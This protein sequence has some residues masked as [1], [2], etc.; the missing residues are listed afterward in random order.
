M[1]NRVHKIQDKRWITWRYVHTKEN[2]ADLGSRGGHVTQDNDLWWYGPKWLSDP[3]A[4]PMDVTTTAT[5]ETLSEAKVIREI[6]KLADD[7]ETDELEALLNKHILWKTLRI[8][9]WITRFARNARSLPQERKRGPLTTE[10]L[11]IQ[12]QAWERRAQLE[13]TRSESFVNDRLQ[14]NLQRNDQHLFECRGRIQGVYP[15]YLPDKCVY[16][17]KFIQEAH[18]A[19]LHGGVQLTMAKV[20]EQHW[21]PRLRRQVKRIVKKCPGCKRFQATA[22]AVPPPGLLPK[23]RTEGSFPFQV[24]GVD[25]AGPIKYKATNKREGKAY[26]ILYACSLT[27]ALYL[28]LV[29][30]MQTTEFLLSLKGMI[31]RRGRPS[32]I[33]SDNGSTFIGA[34]AWLKQVKTDEKLN[35][36]LARQQIT[37]RFNLSRAPWWGGQFERM[38]GLVKVAMRKAVGNAYL[39]FE[40]LKEV[41]LDVEIAL[42]GRPLSYVEDDE[43]LPILTPY[44]MLLSQPNVL[45]E[46]EAHHEE[47]PQLRKRLKY[48]KKCKD[49]LWARWTQ[50]YLR[51]LRERHTLAHKETPCRIQRGVVCIIKDESKDRNKWKLGI[52]EELITGRDGIVRA[53]KLRAGKNYLERAVQQLYPLELSCDRPQA[54]LRA[55]VLNPEAPVYKPRRDAAVAAELR[56]Q[57]IAEYDQNQ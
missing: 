5:A 7:Q 23:E 8:S 4:W 9:A 56:V 49:A 45:P 1:H 57:E 2:P 3:S 51:G 17:E 24:V 39:T 21:V 10:E 53:V 20:R 42:N 18:E 27:R 22:L 11:T 32:T 28:D 36:F 50:K 35:D 44:S 31:A 19:T 15:V 52:V 54:P 16:T 25:Y 30:S 12:R 6:F 46:R 48:L 55:P 41:I 37:W 14:L 43:Q 13:G 33:Y 26:I 40:E 29:K 47:V 34:A 38:V